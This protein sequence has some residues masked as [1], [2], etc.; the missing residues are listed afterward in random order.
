VSGHFEFDGGLGFV[1]DRGTQADEGGDSVKEAATTGRAGGVD[2]AI[3]HLL[4]DITPAFV[5]AAEKGQVQGAEILDIM[6]YEI[7]EGDAPGLVDGSGAAR[8]R[9]IFKMTGALEVIVVGK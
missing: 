8:E 1:V 3:D 4:D 2:L 5:N 7:A 6:F 9:N